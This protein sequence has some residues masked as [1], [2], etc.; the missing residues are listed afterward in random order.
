M[1]ALLLSIFGPI[2]MRVENKG[3]LSAS[4]NQRRWKKVDLDEAKAS[5]REDSAE[6]SR[7]SIAR[8]TD[9]KTPGS[10]GRSADPTV[11]A[12]DL[13]PSDEVSDERLLALSDRGTARTLTME[14]TA[15]GP[16]LFPEGQT[17]KRG[18]PVGPGSIAVDPSVIPLGTRLFVEGYGFGIAN[19]TGALIVGDRIDVWLPSEKKCLEWGR[20][21][22]KVTVLG[23]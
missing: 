18:D 17:T 21:R 16:P 5:R 9:E 7:G 12:D 10:V 1:A 14:A 20:R 15:Y 19:D 6:G 4:F 8:R 11:K 2:E 23:R 3:L 13:A 22:V